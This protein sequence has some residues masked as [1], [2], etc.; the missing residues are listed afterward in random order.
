M[1]DRSA[2]TLHIHDCP[3][4]QATAALAV[5]DEHGLNMEWV[6][7]APA[8]VLYAGRAYTDD[9]A[10]LGSEDT[11]A[12]ALIEAAPGCAF[13]IWQDP[14]YE[15][16]GELAMYDPVLGRF[17]CRC[18]ANGEPHLTV[19]VIDAALLDCLERNPNAMAGDLATELHRRFGI[20]WTDQFDLYEQHEVVP[21]PAPSAGMACSEGDL[22]R[23]ER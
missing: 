8:D 20:P 1:S 21:V 6:D 13:T 9:E 7:P 15:Y 4:D 2:L 3:A 18:N 14:K 23:T 5:I 11:I 12:S 22:S 16:D 17:S 10:S 19:D